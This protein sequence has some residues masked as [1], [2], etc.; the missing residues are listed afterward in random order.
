[1]KS[2]LRLLWS[3]LLI[4]FLCATLHAQEISIQALVT[5]STVITKDGR[6][7]RFAIH[8]FIEFGSLSELFPYIDSQA[9]RWP[10]NPAFDDAKRQQLAR[11]SGI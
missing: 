11:S 1:M 3:A 10:D 5:P 2:L 6:P 8:G 7:V 9:R 4:P